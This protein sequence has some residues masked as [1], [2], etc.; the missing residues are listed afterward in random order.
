M[1]AFAWKVIRGRLPTKD[2]LARRTMANQNLNMLCELC[3]DEMETVQHLFFRC[4]IAY[5]VWSEIYKW[6]G[7]SSV[8]NGDG[9]WKMCWFGVI[10]FIWLMRNKLIFEKKKM[11]LSQVVHLIKM[12]TW[13][14]CSVNNNGVC[15]LGFQWFF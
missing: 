12:R 14:W 6:W 1:I 2:Q 11:E 13:L 3:N 9:V 10:W 5:R 7:F 8:L 15:S 4:K